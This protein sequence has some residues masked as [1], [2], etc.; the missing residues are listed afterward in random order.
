MYICIRMY[1]YKH[2]DMCLIADADGRRILRLLLDVH[3][4]VEYV[5]PCIGLRFQVC[6]STVVLLVGDE[7]V[8]M[9]GVDMSQHQEGLLG[10]D[11]SRRRTTPIPTRLTNCRRH[12]R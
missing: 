8:R 11:R 12:N 5:K 10:F 1:I 4:L 2:T 7:M 3:N 9:C 6:H